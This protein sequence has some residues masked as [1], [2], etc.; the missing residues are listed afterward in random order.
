ME[1]VG[2]VAPEL[3]DVESSAPG[4]RVYA[5]LDAALAMGPVDLVDVV[6]LPESEPR[7]RLVRQ[8]GE[9]GCDV[10][11]ASPMARATPDA[12]G[13][14]KAAKRCRVRVAVSQPWRFSPALARTKEVVGSGVLGEGLQLRWRPR[15]VEARLGECGGL[16]GGDP[17]LGALC[18]DMDVCNWVLGAPGGGQP[19]GAAA[20]GGFQVQYANSAQASVTYGGP[21]EGPGE[22]SGAALL[23][24]GANGSLSLS[25]SPGRGGLPASW[26]LLLRV[27]GRERR[28]ALPEGSG[29]L[30]AQTGYLAACLARD[31][32]WSF[33]PLVE[34]RTAL[35]MALATR[36]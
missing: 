20:G 25:V 14:L 28:L 10:L 19:V 13:V 30:R 5:A 4:L 1:V 7:A 17:G 34:A 36:H 3:T 35:S 16:G 27:F 22:G 32:P 12:D 8:L 2:A 18:R 6:S 29:L 33:L 31:V 24:T 21:G 23:V 15:A 9:R 11:L 26:S